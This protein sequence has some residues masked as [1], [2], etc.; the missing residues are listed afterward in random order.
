[1]DGVKAAHALFGGGGSGGHV[2]PG[3]AVAAELRRRGWQVSW[4]GSPGGLEARLV[5]DHELDFYGLPARPV[6]G[7]GVWKKVGAATTLALSAW[8]A[9]RLVR[10][11]GIRVVLG[12]GGYVS[13]PAVVGARLAARPILLVEPNA[14]PGVANRLLSRLATEAAIAYDETATTLHC[15]TSTTGVPIRDEFFAVAP[16]LPEARPLRL[17]VLGGS[18]GA[19]QLNEMLPQALAGLNVGELEVVH[20]CG[21]AGV[22]ATK[23][24]YSGMEG[25]TVTPFLDD[26]AGAMARSHLVVSRA[27]A[28]TLAEICAAGRA[29]LLLPLLM[30]GAHQVANA[31]RL[32]D[33]GAAEMLSKDASPEELRTLLAELLG[34]TSRLQAMG[35]AARGLARANA[36]VAIADRV[37]HLG[38]LS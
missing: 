14:A 33:V 16:E 11:L 25:I 38:G 15:A 28:I 24:A 26:V 1:M 30:A 7:Q 20:Q 6:V 22:A 31:R 21:A 12:T 9:R 37:E 17:L 5:R 8:R 4:V 27:G 29:T 35:R 32:A 10:D 36:A 19:R 2:F 18:Q 13:A 3:L 34:H 23:E